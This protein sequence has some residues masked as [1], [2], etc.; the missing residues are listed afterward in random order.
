MATLMQLRRMVRT[1][2][3]VTATDSFFRDEQIDDS[4]NNAIATFEAER[5]WPW[6]LRS[7]TLTTTIERGVVAVPEDWRAT[8]A[9]YSGRYEVAEVPP[10]DLYG[11]GDDDGEVQVFAHVGNAIHV[12]NIP[13]AGTELI[14]MYYRVPTLLESDSDV[15]DLPAD[16][17]PAIV[18]KAAQLS[19]TREDD[20][21]SAQAHLLEYEQWLTRMLHTGEASKRPKGRRIRPGNW[22]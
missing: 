2:L 13:S 7:T 12:R 3:G 6:Q 10:Y 21:P 18:A 17:Y 16:A 15:P 8:R 22:I 9:L 5:N 4:I 14:L 19:S 20:R 1:R 11:Y